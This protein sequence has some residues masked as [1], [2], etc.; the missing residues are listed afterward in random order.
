MKRTQPV[1]KSKNR[2]KSDKKVTRAQARQQLPI[3]TGSRR[4]TSPPVV[5]TDGA[6]VTITHREFITDIMSTAAFSAG[7]YKLSPSNYF[8]FPWLARFSGMYQKYKIESL[9]ISYE[10]RCASTTAGS[11][12]LCFDYDPT[13]QPPIDKSALMANYRAVASALWMSSNVEVDRREI[14]AKGELYTG[15]ARGDYDSEKFYITGNIIWGTDGGPATAVLAGELY[16]DY[17]ISFR[18]PQ[19]PQYDLET[20]KITGGGTFSSTNFLGTTPVLTPEGAG[21]FLDL[22]TAGYIR[23]LAPWSGLVVISSAGTTMNGSLTQAG[24]AVRVVSSYT[25]TATQFTLILTVNAARNTTLGI[26]MTGSTPLSS[27]WLLR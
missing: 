10:P 19:S 18:L 11:I 2:P 27:D 16:V 25:A 12:F 9:K 14:N 13:D 15:L 6:S 22:S 26:S 17:K 7:S 1:T 20:I 23:F 3:A 8:I 24:N 5:K 4:I 21:R